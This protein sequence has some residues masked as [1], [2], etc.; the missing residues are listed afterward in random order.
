[1][2]SLGIV[3]MLVI[4]GTMASAVFGCIIGATYYSAEGRDFTTYWIEQGWGNHYGSTS[5]TVAKGYQAAIPDGDWIEQESNG[6][7]W[8]RWYWTVEDLCANDYGA[9]FWYYLDGFLQ[10][11]TEDGSAGSPY[12]WAEAG[13]EVEFYASMNDPVDYG[14]DLKERDSWWI[15]V[16]GDDFKEK[17]FS[18]KKVGIYDG[19]YRF[20]ET[21]DLYIEVIVRCHSLAYNQFTHPA[22]DA[23]GHSNFYSWDGIT[24]D[25]LW[26]NCIGGKSE[27][28]TIVLNASDAEYTWGTCEV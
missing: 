22:S 13:I 9:H 27:N 8:H 24:I 5:S 25:E 2:K 6:Y 7:T 16:G 15:E 10:V 3:S 20:T 17:V 19:L 21:G 26:I 23:R 4:V 12:D 11:T 14:S 18:D 28:R 1:M